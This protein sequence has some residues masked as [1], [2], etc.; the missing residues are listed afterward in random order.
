MIKIVEKK[1]NQILSG[2][3]NIQSLEALEELIEYRASD[4]RYFA[5]H[6]NEHYSPFPKTPQVRPFAKKST[7]KKVRWIIQ[8][9]NPLK[10]IQR[11]INKHILAHVKLPDYICGGVIGRSVKFNALMHQHANVLV[12][13]DIQNYFPSIH[14]V[15]LYHIWNETLGCSTEVSDVLTKLTT[16]KGYLPQG[17]PTST[18]LANLFLSTIDAPIRAECARLGISY[19]VWVDD[20]AFS[21]NDARRIIPLAIGTLRR[22]GLVVSRRKFR[23]MG[24]G[25]RKVVTGVVLGTELNVPRNYLN[26]LRAGIHKLRTGQIPLEETE[27][28]L[29]Q[30]EGGIAY[31]NSIN[32]SR[33]NRLLRDLEVAKEKLSAATLPQ[34]H[35]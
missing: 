22:A 11:R 17:A 10:E 27:A 21:G 19:S 35:A 23:V 20:M 6:A 16:Y 25:K 34:S 4:I 33:A 28:Y 32:P 3:P 2:K 9:I 1:Q 12:T 31:V 26:G 18:S 14:D 5:E 29:K 13:I 7:S 30:L 24:L 8:P 15:H